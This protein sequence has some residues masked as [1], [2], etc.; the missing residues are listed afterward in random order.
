LKTKTTQNEDRPAHARGTDDGRQVALFVTCLVDLFRPSIA[1]A[2]VRLLEQSGFTVVVPKQGCCGQPNYNG[3]DRAGAATMA[4]QT[5]RIFGAFEYV[6]APS[7]SCAAMIRC[8]YPKLFETGSAARREAEALASRTF[9]LTT[10]LTD[11]AGVSTSSATLQGAATYHDACAGL[12]ELN[13]KQQPRELLGAVAGL[14]L[15]DMP[16]TEACCG[17]GGMFCVKYPELSIRIAEQ[18]IAD[19][20]KTAADYLI[21]G[22][23]G[24]LMHLEGKLH[25]D[26][27][28]VRVLHVAEVLA[29]VTDGDPQDADV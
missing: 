28:A 10:F 20:E 16:D 21:G 13:I 25:R 11:I 23:L 8:H 17:F 27:K 15:S 24:C 26:G 3:G 5:I 6:V 2:A 14:T 19:V 12:R 4:L 29:G 22:D 7:G 9:E 18:K 1:F